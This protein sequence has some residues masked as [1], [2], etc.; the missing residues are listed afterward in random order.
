MVQSFGIAC[1]CGGMICDQ[2]RTT[3][4]RHHAKGCIACH[5]RIEPRLR[6]PPDAIPAFASRFGRWR[7]VLD[8]LTRDSS[9]APLQGLFGRS[10]GLNDVP[11]DRPD[12]ILLLQPGD[13]GRSVGRIALPVTDAAYSGREVRLRK[14][15]TNPMFDLRATSRIAARSASCANTASTTSEWPWERISKARCTR[16]W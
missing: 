8:R 5:H 12:I 9:L 2:I 6:P 7:H 3:A 16:S 4:A 14:M 1:A 11:V 13:L 10:G 15:P